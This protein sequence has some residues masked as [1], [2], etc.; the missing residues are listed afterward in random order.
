MAEEAENVPR[1]Q[2]GNLS[3]LKPI[4]GETYAVCVF[5]GDACKEY[6]RHMV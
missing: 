3:F 2:G 5:V 1:L 4:L 6:D